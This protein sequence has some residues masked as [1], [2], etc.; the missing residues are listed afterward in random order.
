VVAGFV[1]ISWLRKW[2]KEEIPT[3][4][5]GFGLSELRQMHAR[6]ELT[7]EE[8][9]RARG[10]LTASAK[11]VTANMPDPA[12]GRRAPRSPPAGGGGGGGALNPK[13]PG[14]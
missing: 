10:K 13:R 7:D 14:P 9:E 4:G 11:A 1:V 3:G 12:G 8:Y 5:L 2:M 6:G